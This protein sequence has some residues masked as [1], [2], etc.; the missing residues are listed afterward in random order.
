MDKYLT[1]P[2]KRNTIVNQ[3][4]QVWACDMAV[5]IGVAQLYVVRAALSMRT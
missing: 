5:G 3:H 4:D 2:I 1:I